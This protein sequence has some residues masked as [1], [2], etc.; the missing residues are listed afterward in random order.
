MKG[1][2]MTPAIQ[3][4]KTLMVEIGELFPD[5]IEEQNM[6]TV[7]ER[8]RDIATE[9][10]VGV[11]LLVA[12]QHGLKVG[13]IPLDRDKATK[14][15]LDEQVRTLNADPYEFVHVGIRW[16]RNKNRK[17][18]EEKILNERPDPMWFFYHEDALVS[19]YSFDP[20]K[21]QSLGLPKP[22]DDV[23]R[24]LEALATQQILVKA[25]LNNRQIQ[26]KDL[27]SKRF[28]EASSPEV[29]VLVEDDLG[30]KTFWLPGFGLGIDIAKA[31]REYVLAALRYKRPCNYCSIQA[32][33]PREA[34]LHSRHLASVFKPK[35]AGPL[36]RRNYQFG[37]TFAPFGDPRKVC[38]FLAWDFPHISDTVLNMDPQDYSFADLIELVSV[39]NADILRFA[40]LR[41][42][43][44]FEP[45]AGVCNHWAGN[46]I[47]H[48]HYQF[49]AIQNLPLLSN[50]A[51]NSN[52]AECGNVTVSRLQW[53]P[54]AYLI[55]SDG[56]ASSSEIG[57]VAE[58]VA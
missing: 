9:H 17:L 53:E 34:T 51:Q 44:P 58:R 54:P 8:L 36:T 35:A 48:Q 23:N 40:Q 30:N 26:F 52:L 11:A 55:T 28:L 47:Y 14:A 18:I 3:T 45:I 21:L 56:A 7:G 6:R 27:D 41:G 33:N 50:L 32:L 57:V 20:S 43:M 42:V 2:Q 38:H 19:P 22:H 31:L 29:C 12:W 15:V 25:N 16:M 46:S 4:M 1:D 37:F 49:F 10:G 24:I 13:H 39:I 5:V